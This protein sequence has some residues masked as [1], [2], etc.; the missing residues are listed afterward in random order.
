M[1]VS[2][3]TGYSSSDVGGPGLITGQAATLGVI[4]KACLVDGYPGKAAAGWSNP[5]AAAGN[6]YSFK[7]GAGSSGLGF[8]LND[9]GPN[10][11][12]TYKE[13]WIT[14]WESVAG[15]GAPVGS[16]S[17]QFPTPAQ[18]LTTGHGVIRKSST[19]D[20]ATHSW[21]MWADAY[22][23]ALFILTGDNAG[24]QSTLLFGDIFSLK[25]ATDAYRCLITCQAS[26]NAAPNGTDPSWRNATHANAGAGQFMA[27]TYGGGGTSILVQT[28]ADPG[29]ATGPVGAMQAPNGPDNAYHMAPWRVMEATGKIMRGRVRGIYS[30]LHAPATFVDGQTF[31]GAGDFAG[32]T[33]EVVRDVCGSPSGNGAIAIETSA[34]VETN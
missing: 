29:M 19:A 1:S 31:N 9:N 11:T 28:M 20:G 10:V 30:L 24:I 16:G 21:R 8:V 15:V 26:E 27:R 22:S 23:M 32:K 18:Q 33:F 13:A 17:G 25:G 3:F 6:I 4:L 34:T 14:G 2:Q 7:N 5:V 12:S